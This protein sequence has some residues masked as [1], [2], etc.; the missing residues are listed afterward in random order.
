MEKR[1][2]E[3]P[4]AVSQNFGS[5]NQSVKENKSVFLPLGSIASLG[6]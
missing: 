4:D 6:I 1:L 5:Q 3:M 2:R